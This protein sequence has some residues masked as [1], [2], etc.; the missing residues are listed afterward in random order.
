MDLMALTA[1]LS[2]DS[3]EYESGLTKAKGL[4]STV[5]GKL[6]N[7]FGTAAKI[8]IGAIGA[9]TAAVG[10]FIKSS[11]D[12]GSSFDSAM[13]QVAATMNKSID[14]IS[15]LREFAKEMGATTS[16]S[17]TQAA[18]AL[19]YMALAGYDANTSMQMLPNVLNLAAAGNMEL[20]T[21]SD[22]VTDAQSA[23]G[24]TLE[25]T[26]K[27]VDQMAMTASKSNTSVSQLGEAILTIGATARGVKGGTVELSTVLGA[28]ADNGI[29]GAEGGTH[30]RNAIL[31]LQTPTK[32][33]AAALAQLGMSYADMYDEAGNLRSLPEIFQQ[34]SSA[35]EGMTQQSKDAIVSGIFNKTDLAAMNALLGT[36]K[37]RW[38]ELGA[39]IEDSA[40]AAKKMADTQLDN[41]QGDVIKFKSALE[42]AQILLSDQLTP[43]LREFVKFGTSGI[44]E[45]S[46][47][48]KS[49]GL[50][51]VLD[52]A[53]ELL[54]E[55]LAKLI[56]FAPKVISI[57]IGL[58]GSLTG[59]IVKNI[60][61]ISSALVEGINTILAQISEAILGYN[62][63]DD[64]SSLI[65]GI[66]DI[67]TQKIP[68]FAKNAMEWGKGLIEGLG[69]SIN[70]AGGIS[71]IFNSLLNV[72]VTTLKSWIPGIAEAGT[73]MINGLM[74]AF[75]S[76]DIS[77]M[78][79]NVFSAFNEIG[80]IIL[81]I[82]QNAGSTIFNGMMNF[83]PLFTQVAIE[84]ISTLKEGITTALPELIP[85]ALNALMEFSGALRSNV[86]TIVSAGLDLILA[87]AQGLI[88]N[89]PVMIQTIPTIVTNIA[90]IINDNA[91]KLLVAGVALIGKLA[92]GIVKSIP[93]I[94]AEFPKIIQAIISV[95]SAVNWINL[96]QNAIKFIGNGIKGLSKS[97]PEA[98]KNIAQTAK[99]WF[100]TIQW[101][102]LGQDIIDLIVIGIQS[103]I[104]AIPQALMSIGQSAIAFI[105]GIDWISVGSNI[106]GIIAGAISAGIGILISILS[107]MWTV[108]ST[109]IST[110]LG[111]ISG[112][113]SSVMGVISGIW[114]SIWNAIVSVLSSVWSSISSTV[115]S[116]ISA[117][118][119]VISSVL[120]GIKSTF[121]SVWNAIKST[122]SNVIN[123]IKS[124]ISNGLN[125]AKSTV[126]SI[127]NSIRSAITNAI[128]GAKAAVTNAIAAI[129]GAFNFSWSLPHLSLPHI[130]ISGSFSLNPPSVPHFGI[131]WYK[132]A[133]QDPFL[134]DGASIFGALGNN[135]LGGGEA[136]R[137]IVIGE[138]KA[139]DLIRK[140][141]GDKEP[142]NVTINVYARENQNVNA[143]AD[144]ISRKLQKELDRRRAVYA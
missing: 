111:V 79:E 51:A 116:A 119:S 52:V 108:I 78:I 127:F 95:W 91:P 2:L 88:D 58:I 72:V 115:S 137:E 28:L 129:K 32:D 4:A 113:I 100:S 8:G 48:F 140:A 12:A 56:G 59:A 124:T 144:V 1:R 138:S 121:T 29:K 133:M 120:D 42:G 25:Q 76:V 114:S 109:V 67:T 63:F 18:E 74:E 35:M 33:G 142:V 23:L 87:L 130:S 80:S 55:L 134:L 84:M 101:S 5:G 135:L 26:G 20:A 49:G 112:V 86:S 62:M 53:G 30:L 90:G 3:S 125:A 85:S 38:D 45:L 94:I 13:A 16:F 102:T 143:L 75:T 57:V 66:L 110:A 41:L 82:I 93:T 83:L 17:A 117:V 54:E 122:V 141:S 131:S 44:T 104:T 73:E 81:P 132:K 46:D 64:F 36:S 68:E 24:L 105:M 10:V 98:L 92:A 69:E 11:I 77:S 103:L 97:I 65:D 71:N 21:A 37:D 107:A 27:M 128:N 136:G 96:G 6:K 50:N 118:S 7:A 47:A 15:D 89:L 19:N 40:G 61:T 126:T 34:M 14:E 39:A 43:S 60:P 9:A 70:D 123:N 31:S 106:I 22:M 99:D 139:I